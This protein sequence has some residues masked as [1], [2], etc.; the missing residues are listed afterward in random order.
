MSDIVERLREACSHAHYT[1]Q[2]A[3]HNEAAAEI[4]RLRA[5]EVALQEYIKMAHARDGAEIERLRAALVAIKYQAISLADAQVLAL[6][7][8]K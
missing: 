5:K 6:E 1:W 2:S 7:A 8:L 4:E 3:L